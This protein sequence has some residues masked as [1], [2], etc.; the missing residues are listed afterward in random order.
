LHPHFHLIGGHRDHQALGRLQMVRALGV[1][2]VHGLAG[3][4]FN[5]PFGGHRD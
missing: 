2:I 4:A 1:G 3:S 5:R